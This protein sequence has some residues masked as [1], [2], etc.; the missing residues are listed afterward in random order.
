MNEYTGP[1]DAYLRSIGIAM[2]VVDIASWIVL[3]VLL[4]VVYRLITGMAR[5]AGF[6]EG[7]RVGLREKNKAISEAYDRGVSDA[8]HESSTESGRRQKANINTGTGLNM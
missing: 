5:A 8:R 7:H 1:I 2:S 3:A 6:D 4:Y